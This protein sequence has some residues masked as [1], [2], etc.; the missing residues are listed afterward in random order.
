MAWRIYKVDEKGYAI[1][2]SKANQTKVKA[3]PKPKA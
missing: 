3:T 1:D 2:H